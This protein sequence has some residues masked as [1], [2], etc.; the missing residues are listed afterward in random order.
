MVP[1]TILNPSSIQ[2][3]LGGTVIFDPRVS[4]SSKGEHATHHGD[5]GAQCE[6]G[7]RQGGSH[8]AGNRDTWIRVDL[9]E[10]RAERRA[11]AE[12]TS[13]L[14]QLRAEKMLVNSK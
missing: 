14:S 3:Q 8:A 9:E 13:P 1:A 12:L 10:G 7:Y 5:K 2:R 11:E 6:A 4:H